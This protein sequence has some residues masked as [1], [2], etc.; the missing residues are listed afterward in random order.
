LF[1]QYFD[2]LIGFFKTIYD[3]G[4]DAVELEHRIIFKVGIFIELMKTIPLSFA[5]DR[6]FWRRNGRVMAKSERRL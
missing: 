2:F 6:R 1:G 3:E 4:L 5:L